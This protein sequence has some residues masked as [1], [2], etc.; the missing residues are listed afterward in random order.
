MDS[1]VIR[2]VSWVGVLVST[3]APGFGQIQSSAAPRAILRSMQIK[4]LRT[5][6]RAIFGSFLEPIGNAIYGG[7]WADALTTPASST[8]FGPRERSG[9]C[10]R[11]VRN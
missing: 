5:G 7:R 3:S 9:R 6:F 1:R 11:S 10:S 8:I 4:S 2:I